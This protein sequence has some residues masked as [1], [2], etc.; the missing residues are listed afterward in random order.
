[1]CSCSD[2]DNTT[3]G[4]PV[5]SG[6]IIVDPQPDSI[7]PPWLL[8]GPGGFSHAGNGD[9]T[10]V[11]LGAGDY[12]LTWGD[13]PD[14]TIPG[15][16]PHDVQLVAWDTLTIQGTY[17]WVP[18]V[19]TLPFPGSADVLMSNFR[20]IY[21]TRDFIEYRKIMHPDFLTI[22]QDATVQE[23]P[24]VGTTLDVS[25]ELRIHERMFSGDAVTDPQ[26][27]L[28][29]GVLS[30]DFNNFR[31]LDDWKVSPAGD[32]I[33]NAQ[34]APFEVGLLFDRGQNF[35]TLRVEGTIKFYVTSRDSM[36]QDSLEQYYQ[37]IGQVDFQ[38]FMKESENIPW[39]SVKALYW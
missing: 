9:T 20:T 1:L 7:S 22:L 5:S 25:E 36:H 4:P 26:G 15:P 34:W 2:D 3:T 21:E 38:S 19:P 18:P 30:I 11:Q 31:A 16:N 12:S 27:V 14:W 24:D 28:V 37:M 8:V 29:P 32:I 13:Y 35:S 10:F 39:G 17:V 23:F 6:T 33:P